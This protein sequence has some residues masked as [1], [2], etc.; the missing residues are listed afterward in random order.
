MPDVERTTRKQSLKMASAIA[1]TTLGLNSIFWVLS[2]AYYDDK[3]ALETVN[4][5]SVRLAFFLLTLLIAAMSYVAG[6]APRLLGHGVGFAAGI[7]SLVAGIASLGSNIPGVVGV[8]LLILGI[9]LPAVTWRSLQHSRT[10]WAF[11]CALLSVLATVT[12]FGAPKVRNVLDIGLWYAMII[13][14][15]GIVA[16]IALSMVRGEYRA[17][18]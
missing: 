8:A 10:A 13:P 6:L 7:A 3:P 2:I 5:F 4:I 1:G 11:L 17:R 18:A 14:A 16:V 15:V 9:V 12:F